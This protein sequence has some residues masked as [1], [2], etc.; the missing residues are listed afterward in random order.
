MES[1]EKKTPQESVK[2]LEKA[3]EISNEAIKKAPRRGIYHSTK[4]EILEKLG[5]EEEAKELFEKAKELGYIEE[6]D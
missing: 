4:G 6:E 2:I 5:K 1:V 3:L